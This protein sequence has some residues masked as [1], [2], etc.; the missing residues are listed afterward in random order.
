[1]TNK[2]SRTTYFDP[3]EIRRRPVVAFAIGATVFYAAADRLFITH[4]EEIGQ[5][6]IR[7]VHP[8]VESKWL[9]ATKG[10]RDAYV[11]GVVVKLA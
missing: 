10:P 2:I 4:A 3:A 8:T 5:I 11:A 1:M 7:D 6:A 9:K